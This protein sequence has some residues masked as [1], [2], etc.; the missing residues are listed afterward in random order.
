[1]TEE[2]Q[3]KDDAPGNGDVKELFGRLCLVTV[4]R[5]PFGLDYSEVVTVPRSGN[6]TS[7]LLS[8]LSFSRLPAPEVPTRTDP[9]VKAAST[10]SDADTNILEG[11]NFDRH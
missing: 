4:F 8:H 2:C 9:A 10:G 5:P 3:A 11:N 7:P 1:M 6:S